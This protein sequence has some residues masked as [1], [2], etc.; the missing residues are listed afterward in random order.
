M[1]VFKISL[2]PGWSGDNVRHRLTFQRVHSGCSVTGRQLG[3]HHAVQRQ[4]DDISS[5]VNAFI[6]GWPSRSCCS[7]PVWTNQRFSVSSSE[8]RVWVIVAFCQLSGRNGLLWSF[9]CGLWSFYG[10]VEWKSCFFQSVFWN[11]VIKQGFCSLLLSSLCVSLLFST[12]LQE[13]RKEIV[14][15]EDI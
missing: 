3:S 12:R 15:A 8:S 4:M 7:S 6:C 1:S 13:R 9:V 14:E 10:I 11:W 2:Q 5:T